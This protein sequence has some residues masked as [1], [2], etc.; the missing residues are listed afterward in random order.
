MKNLLL[1]ALLIAT[2]AFSAPVDSIARLKE[3][4]A[5]PPASYSTLPFFVWNGE[6]TEAMIDA[7]LRDY[8]A[9]HI[10]GFF[11]HPRPGLITE[12]LSNRWFELV[13][14]TVTQAKKLGMEVWLYDENSYPSG[15]AGGH[16][17]AQ[18]PESYNEGQGLLPKKLP[19]S[20]GGTNYEVIAKGNDGDYGFERVS[21]QRSGWYGGFSYVDL[22]KPGV[23]EKFIALTMPG[24][25][26]SLGT[27]LGKAVPGMFTDE[28]NINPPVRRSLR[29]TPD[30]FPQFEKRW[31]YDLKPHLMALYQETGD[32]RKVRHDYYALLLELFVD[33]WSKPW[34]QY[35]DRK[36]IAWTGHY[37]EH[38]WPNPSQGPDNMAMYAYHHVPGIDMLFNQFR[39]DVSAQ[40][41]NIRSVKELAS[42]AN[43]MGARRTLSETYGGGGWELRFED[44]KRL[45][46]WQSVLGVN[47]MN[48]HLSFGTIAGARK[49]DYPQSFTYHTP[50]WK[51][52]H[53]LQDYFARLSLAL[54][55]GEQVNRILVLEPTTSA[56]MYA[57]PG[58]ANPRMMAIGHEFQAFVTRLERLQSEYDLGS[59][60]IILNNGR[61][62]GSKFVVGK[63]TYDVVVLPPGTE[64]IEAGVARMI[65][66]YVN[67][68]GTVMSFVDPPAR[69]EGKADT[70][71]A[72]LA[73]K[74]PKRWLRATSLDDATAVGKLVSGD[75]RN[76]NG[77]LFHQRRQLNGGQV[78]FFTNSSLDESAKATVASKQPLLKMDLFTGSMEPY[79]VTAG[80]LN[81]DLAPGGS[82]LLI[83][84][85]GA[86]PA[87]KFGVGGG[88]DISANSPMRVKRATANTLRI[89]YCDL[90]IGDNVDRDIYFYAAQEKV[91]KHFGLDTN[92][93]NHAVQY[94]QSILDRN[95]F[96][97]GSSFTADF[98]FEVASG[99]DTTGW[100]VAVE[101][102]A[103]WKVSLNGGSIQ[104][105]K[106]EWWL[107]RDFGVYDIGSHVKPGVNTITLTAAQ[108]TVH[109]E[110]EPVHILGDFGVM[111]Q[112][113]GWKLTPPPQLTTGSWKDQ[114]LPFYSHEVI[115]SKR[116]KGS[117]G[118]YM[119]ELGKWHGTVAEVRV[120]GK[121]AGIV[122][123]QP[124]QIEITK[125]LTS[126][127]NTVEV[128]VTGSL[129]NL[130]GPH[131][132]KINR[133]LT[134]PQSFR[135]APAHQP[136]GIS[137]D[138]EAYGLMEPFRVVALSAP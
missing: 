103:L 36:G 105:R 86:T 90:H 39:E 75:I 69:I 53:V 83:T 81:V 128:A 71:M 15:F 123:W 91:F 72:A 106:G 77:K 118:R 79:P 61:A 16:V 20:G 40:F 133:G 87:P 104:P 74:Q 65:E 130:Y 124:Y 28:P 10:G 136:G 24:Y 62:A 115:Y 27:D 54:A 31:G 116:V 26:K 59:E 117:G 89:D 37:W 100:Q 129:K 13:R 60:H 121:S 109:H 70:R 95:N 120:N 17:P 11:I 107:D 134:A 111:A 102:P 131:H 5:K 67:G 132:G 55:S 18:M 8:N 51:H 50:W 125:L 66:Q 88:T 137:Y 45:G 58:D 94:K 22:L 101:R 119:V 108:M 3:L 6:M 63:R 1:A 80:T 92:P 32:W 76:V 30:L 97:P 98:H 82:L 114:R 64:S 52:Y 85:D 41:G 99:S 46:D 34:R 96:P 14:Y 49:Y 38:A 68:G 12:Y 43:Q 42:V 78:L 35:T 73:G 57:S 7:Q 113:R 33:R 122:G 29:W 127:D 48:Q 9:Q 23:T 135:S 21:Y 110:L 44:M 47:M 19:P 4:F 56:W 126:G 93:W 84:G 112:D 138:M 25:E 2:A